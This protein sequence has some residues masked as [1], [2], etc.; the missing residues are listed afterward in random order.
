[1]MTTELIGYIDDPT[2]VDRM[3]QRK[4]MHRDTVMYFLKQ[5]LLGFC[6]ILLGITAPILSTEGG[7]ISLLLIPYG[8][9]MIISKSKMVTDGDSSIK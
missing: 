2:A 6:M 5:K 9:A 7:V 1:M 4:K 8:L 3:R